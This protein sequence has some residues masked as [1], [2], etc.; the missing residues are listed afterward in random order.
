MGDF[1][2]LWKQLEICNMHN[3]LRG[4]GA[5]STCIGWCINASWS[6]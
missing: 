2:M 5:S 3:W 4:T 6:K 1:K